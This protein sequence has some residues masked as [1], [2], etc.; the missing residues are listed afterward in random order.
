MG[1]FFIHGFTHTLDQALDDVGALI[2]VEHTEADHLTNIIQQPH[3]AS[4]MSGPPMPN[5]TPSGR[6]RE[7]LRQGRPKA[8][9]GIV[10]SDEHNTRISHVPQHPLSWRA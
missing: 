10:R 9:A 6:F 8:V 1:P 2:G 5:T 4:A 3:T 7:L